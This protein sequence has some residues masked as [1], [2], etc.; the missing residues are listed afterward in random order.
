MP[1]KISLSRSIVKTAGL[2]AILT[3]LMS[4]F[5][6]CFIYFSSS[7]KEL[8]HLSGGDYLISRGLWLS[9]ASLLFGLMSI[10]T[11]SGLTNRKNWSRLT[12]FLTAVILTLLVPIGTI[13]GLKLLFNFFSQ[14]MKSWF[15]SGRHNTP[16]R[17]AGQQKPGIKLELLTD[18]VDRQRTNR[19]DS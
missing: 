10:L 8:L 2:L 14:E 6:V 5:L 12:L 4:L 13:F 19:S 9:L 11:A 18:K 3:T 7:E 15:N 1:E 16:A 17:T